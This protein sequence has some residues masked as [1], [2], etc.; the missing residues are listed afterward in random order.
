M[1]AK[2]RVCN[3]YIPSRGE[4]FGGMKICGCI[5]ISQKEMICLKQIIAERRDCGHPDPALEQFYKRCCGN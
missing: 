1:G 2:C 3:G 5:K 4:S